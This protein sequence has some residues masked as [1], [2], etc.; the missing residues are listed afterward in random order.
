MTRQVTLSYD[1]DDDCWYA[2]NGTKRYVLHCGETLE[3]LM[4]GQMVPCRLEVSHDW[5]II[6]P[7]HRFVLHP[8]ERYVVNE[9]V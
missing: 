1:S 5:Y 6:T 9:V 7:E 4:G 8:Q 2:V 3:F